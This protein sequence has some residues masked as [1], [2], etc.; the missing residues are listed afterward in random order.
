MIWKP[1]DSYYNDGF[2]RTL[3]HMDGWLAGGAH[4]T[5]V[6]SAKLAGAVYL[7]Q[8]GT[9][10]EFKLTSPNPIPNGQFGSTVEFHTKMDKRPILYVGAIGEG[11][12][13]VFKWVGNDWVVDAD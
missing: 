10:M 7:I 13:Y 1:K 2:G 11:I 4:K 8:R 3:T 12:V 5:Q 6:G 9:G